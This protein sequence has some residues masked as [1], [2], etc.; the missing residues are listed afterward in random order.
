MPPSRP[1]KFARDRQLP[2]HPRRLKPEEHRRDILG[3]P[4]PIDRWL[5]GNM[6][7]EHAWTNVAF[8]DEFPEMEE[9][10]R[11]QVVCTV[12][13]ERSQ[14]E[15]DPDSIFT[16][17]DTFRLYLSATI[18]G[19]LPVDTPFRTSPRAI[20]DL[21]VGSPDE[22]FAPDW[23]RSERDVFKFRQPRDTFIA[24]F[25]RMALWQDNLNEAR[26]SSA[27]FD[28]ASAISVGTWAENKVPEPRTPRKPIKK[29]NTKSHKGCWDARILK[30]PLD[31]GL[32]EFELTPTRLDPHVIT[33]E[34][35]YLA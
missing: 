7:M 8:L 14:P 3:L 1:S 10:R 18:S 29:W 22:P 19:N 28:W 6:K 5:A 32:K 31:T 34:I 16:E 26:L 35:P 25:S 12:E 17:S 15:D 21:F 23:V 13:R 33:G 20:L 2:T 11:N 24:L 4:G 30:Q 9:V 27:M